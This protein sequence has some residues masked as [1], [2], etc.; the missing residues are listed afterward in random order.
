MMSKTYFLD[1]NIFIESNDVY[2]QFKRVPE[3]WNFLSTG[4]KNHNLK[5][6]EGIHE[7]IKKGDSDLEKFAVD[8]KD[9]VVETEEL[10][11]TY[12]KIMTS[13]EDANKERVD[14][15]DKIA[16][17]S[18][19]GIINLNNDIRLIADAYRCGGIVVTNEKGRKD[20]A[21]VDKSDKALLYATKKGKVPIP[22]ICYYYGV[23]WMTFGEFLDEFGFSTSNQYESW[24]ES[25]YLPF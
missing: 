14:D 20:L 13:I 4:Y 25:V 8:H 5:M 11:E 24:E 3:F 15:K 9:S 17:L 18:G 7:E 19:R 2:Y 23:K 21:K 16:T 22:N 6:S 12:I 10:D 1:A